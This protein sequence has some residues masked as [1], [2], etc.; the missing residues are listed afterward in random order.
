LKDLILGRAKSYFL[1]AKR[2]KY[3][4]WGETGVRDWQFCPLAR[5]EEGVCW[6]I[7]KPVA[8]VSK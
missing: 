8:K 6:R 3:V 2:V 1:T 5:F 4:L 7:D